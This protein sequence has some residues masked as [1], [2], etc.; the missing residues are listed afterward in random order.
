MV[1]FMSDRSG[2]RSAASLMASILIYICRLD[3]H[4]RSMLSHVYTAVVIHF[5]DAPIVHI[6]P[7]IYHVTYKKCNS[8]KA[9]Y[10]SVSDCIWMELWP[11]CFPIVTPNR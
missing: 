6:V 9:T 1:G 8:Y 4:L 3:L 2:A 7:F 5:H 11:V 10:K